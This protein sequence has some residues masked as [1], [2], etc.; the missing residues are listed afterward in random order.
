MSFDGDTIVESPLARRWLP[1]GLGVGMIMMSVF[2]ML[3][4]PWHTLGV[5]V[6]LT[7]AVFFGLCLSYALYRAVFPMPVVVLGR[8]GFVDNASAVSVGFVP[9]HEVMA[10]STATVTTQEFVAVTLRR[11]SL[12]LDRQRPWKRLLLRL[13]RRWWAG[14]VF[15]P[16]TVLPMTASALISE[17]SERQRQ[18][19]PL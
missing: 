19:A 3:A 1:V 8:E 12:M 6:G 11:P 17:M 13:S 16:T 10:F 7:G 9:W 14:D 15:I 4:S 2:I 5:A 18:A